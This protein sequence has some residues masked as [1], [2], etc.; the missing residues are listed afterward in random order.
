MAS[1][2]PFPLRLS[3]YPQKRTLALQ[4]RAAVEELEACPETAGKW[5]VLMIGALGC[6]NPSGKNGLNRLVAF[7][8]G[9]GR[10][11]AHRLRPLGPTNTFES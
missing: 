4:V 1:S 6:V 10:R 9:G 7:T 3:P 5:D 8:G 11:C 2:T